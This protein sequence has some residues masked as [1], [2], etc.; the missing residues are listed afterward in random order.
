MGTV[1]AANLALEMGLLNESELQRISALY[2]ALKLKTVFPSLPADEVYQTMLGDKKV[3]A[4]KLR[5]VLP[6]G[7]GG[8]Y[9]VEDIA[10]EQIIRAIQ[11]AQN[12][13]QS[14]R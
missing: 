14:N 9:I 13:N 8:Y 6:K 1:A 7:I 2:H 5:L 10:K 12:M 4:D 3:Q 11:T